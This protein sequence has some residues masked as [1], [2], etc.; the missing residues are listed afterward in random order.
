MQ[1]EILNL[2]Q[3]N[4]QLINQVNSLQSNQETQKLNILASIEQKD[5][6]I[7]YLQDKINQMERQLAYERSM[8]TQ[9]LICEK[10][11]MKQSKNHIMTEQSPTNYSRHDL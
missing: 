8:A 11:R 3:T 2:K 5:C 6:N 10:S 1:L 9:L 4:M 7:M